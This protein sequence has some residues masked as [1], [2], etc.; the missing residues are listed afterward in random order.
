MGETEA[1]IEINYAGY[2]VL[3]RQD[4]LDEGNFPVI[5]VKDLETRLS[6]ALAGISNALVIASYRAEF[7]ACDDKTKVHT[8]IG[9]GNMNTRWARLASAAH[10]S[11]VF[12]GNLQS[13]AQ[14]VHDFRISTTP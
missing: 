6:N 14:V 13:F 3:T 7:I 12:G 9:A 2:S 4:W 11:T 1:V 5:N 10:S 8:L